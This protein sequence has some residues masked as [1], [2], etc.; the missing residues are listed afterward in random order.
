QFTVTTRPTMPANRFS[1]GRSAFTV[2]YWSVH[3]RFNSS[4]RA[5][6]LTSFTGQSPPTPV[7]CNSRASLAP[8]H[9]STQLPGK[10]EVGQLKHFL[11]P[12]GANGQ[13]LAAF[14]GRSVGVAGPAPPA[15]AGFSAAAVGCFCPQQ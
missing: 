3:S 12:G 5:T 2:M 15:R 10:T 7:G 13:S 8:A 9:L 1:S 14:A 11:T 4:L 6:P